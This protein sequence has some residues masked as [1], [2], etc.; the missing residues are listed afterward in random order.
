[1][2]T[3]FNLLLIFLSSLVFTSCPMDIERPHYFI[4]FECDAPHSI[5]CLLLLPDNYSRTLP[6]QAN[7]LEI[8]D[9]DVSRTGK[10]DVGIAPWSKYLTFYPNDT[11]SFVIFHADTLERYPWD[12]IRQ[13]NKVLVRYDIAAEDYSK[14]PGTD[15]LQMNMIVPYPPIPSMASVHMYPPYEKVMEQYEEDCQKIAESDGD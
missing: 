6:E 12:R 13:E 11:I 1:M 2:K 3:K 9:I 10:I 7:P 15:L 5:G 14:L 8:V 4:L